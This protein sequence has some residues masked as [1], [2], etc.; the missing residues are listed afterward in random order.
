MLKRNKLQ[1]L[2]ESY[3]YVNIYMKL[4]KTGSDINLKDTIVT[5]NFSTIFSK[6]F[7]IGVVSILE[8]TPDKVHI[9]A[10]IMSFI[11]PRSV[12]QVIILFL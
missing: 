9:K 11:Y 8:E 10:Q 1:G 3:V 5:S 6:G 12:D 7:P 2:L 4:I